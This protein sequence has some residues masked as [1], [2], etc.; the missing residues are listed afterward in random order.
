MKKLTLKTKEGCFRIL[1]ICIVI[2]LLSGLI[3]R[4]FQ[5]DFGKIKVERVSIDTRGAILNAE[6]YYPVGTTDRDSLP[7]IVVTHGGGCTLGVTK[8]I[9]A[10]MARRGFAVLNVS[11]YGTGLSDQPI[12]EEAGQGQD[13]FNIMEAISGIYDAIEYMKTLTF[14][15]AT[16][17][18]ALGHSLGAIRLYRAAGLDA[19]YYTF[20]DIMINVLYNKF[21]LEFTEEQIY[22]DADEL[23]AEYLSE[24]QLDHY[25]TLRD[26]EYSNYD[27]RLK[28]CVALG[29]TSTACR[30]LSTVEVAGYEVTRSMQTNIAAVNGNY[31]NLWDYTTTEA[32]RA[33]WYAPDGFSTARW[34]ALDDKLQ[35][36]TDLGAFN[37]ISIVDNAALA[38]SIENGNT[39]ILIPTGDETHSKEFFS[40]KTI[41]VLANYYAQTLN[42]NRGDLTDTSTIPLD[43]TD[44]IWAGRAVFNFVAMLAMFGIMLSICCLILTTKRFKGCIC[45]VDDAARSNLNKPTYLIGSLAT[46]AFTFIAIYLAN[47]NGTKLFSP[48]NLLPVSKGSALLT[49]FLLALAAGGLIVLVFNIVVS[50]RQ[51]G[52]YGIA[53]LNLRISIRA[54]AKCLILSIVLIIIGYTALSVSEYFFGQD[55]RFWMISLSDMKVEWWA[56]G[57][58]YAIMWFPLYLILSA[59]INFT[60]RTDIPVWKDTLIT[61]IVNSAGIWLCCLINY[62][63]ARTSYDGTLF[64]NFQSTYQY[65]LWVPITVY[66]ARKMYNLTKNIWSGAFLNTMIITWSIMSSLGVNDG[67]WGPNWISNF[68]NI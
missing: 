41:A 59:G 2:L 33:G 46:I 4:A 22:E 30:W 52:T 3:A 61:V 38:E 68:F 8:G 56:L 26:S 36:N 53:N 48:S 67:Y 34:Y 17:I 5:S 10:E 42:Y 49:Y 57:V 19:G 16:R 6:L 39:R 45:T 62:V 54:L 58:R 20:N 60:I 32:S 64:S 13:G 14:V 18:G 44:Q 24:D 11:A 63:L 9:A 28:A 50:K 31:D 27:T 66:I 23:A 15:D 21:G 35:S 47:A 37:E 40:E 7:G 12:Y 51:T 55:F 43:A 29:M 65:V 1:A 25:Y